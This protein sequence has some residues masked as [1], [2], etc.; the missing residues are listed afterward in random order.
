MARRRLPASVLS[1]TLWLVLVFLLLPPKKSGRTY[2][3]PLTVIRF[4]RL[5]RGAQ[6][7]DAAFLEG[8]VQPRR[9]QNPYANPKDS[10]IHCTL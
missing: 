4:K 1:V 5:H 9:E 6:K 8:A 2:V 7:G 3:R 10:E